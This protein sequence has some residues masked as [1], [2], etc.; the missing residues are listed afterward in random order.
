MEG[1]V[2]CPH[3]PDAGCECRKPRP[4]LIEKACREFSVE[5]IDAP[6]VGDR[7]TDLVAARA[8]GCRPIFVRSGS[9]TE[10]DLGAD[11]PEVP[12][13]DDLAAATEWLLR[14]VPVGQAFGKPS[15]LE[16]A[17]VE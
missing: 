5:A 1:I 14:P 2:H 10:A 3:A 4:G 9:G 7:V 8:A 17:G 16:S 12:R 11:W 15:G 6:F 13:F